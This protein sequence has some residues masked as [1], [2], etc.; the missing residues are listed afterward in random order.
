MKF[1]LCFIFILSNAHFTISQIQ[2]LNDEFENAATLQANWLNIN[3]VEGWNAEHLEVHDINSSSPGELFMMPYTS[4]WY[5]DYRGTLIFKNL[6]QN[7]VLTTEVSTTDRA[8]SGLPSSTFSLAGLMIRS[9]IDYPNGAIND[10]QPNAEN[11]IFMAAGYANSGSGPH[12]EV[13]NTVNGNSNLQITD[14]PTASDVQI[15]IARIGAA[16]IVMFRLPGQNW[17][18]HRRYDRSDFPSD[19]Q[20]GFVTYTDWPKVSSYIPYFHNSNVLNPALNPD[21]SNVAFNPDLIGRFDFAR[22]DD[23]VIPQHL[24]GVNLISQASDADLLSFLGY[25]TNPY[26]PMTESIHDIVMSGQIAQMSVS[27]DLIA[28]NVIESS[29]ELRFTAENSIELDIDF[30]VNIGAFFSAE[31]ASCQ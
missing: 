22:F 6:S 16:I 17:T 21:P 29:A 13:K 8:G 23:L 26:C 4:S 15:R 2:L 9:A 30:E 20:I 11:Y 28:N 14:I 7:F 18:V 24:L 10:W 12:F 25:D 1:F 19:I 27:Q 5:Q 3:D 31:I